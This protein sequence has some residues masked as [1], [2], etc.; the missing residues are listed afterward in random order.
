MVK[1]LMK[2]D[3]SAIYR[4]LVW[5][6]LAA[7]LLSVLVRVTLEVSLRL[8]PTQ[9]NYLPLGLMFAS[10]ASV[11]FWLLSMFA[12]S[13]AG[14]ILCAVRF[15]KSLFTGEGYMTFSLPATPTQLLVAKF[16]SSLIATLSCY[17]AI[18]LGVF[19]ALPFQTVGG[20][21]E[22]L[23]SFFSEMFTYFSAEPFLAVEIVILLLLVIPMGLLYLFLVASIGQLFNKARV[24]ITIALYYGS[25]FVVS[26]FFSFLL[27]PLTMTGANPHV[28]LCLLIVL[29]AA[30]DV[31]SF[32]IIRYLLSRKVNLV[33]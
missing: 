25:T 1:K 12:L 5:F 24:A 15:F 26:F 14:L 27:L 16:L 6:L 10:S 3:L 9:E 29:T 2:H 17:A 21:M 19:I 18:V 30:F 32:F 22:A 7:I 13:Y 28:L 33:V 8:E 11:T 20:A 23:G 31:G 4:V